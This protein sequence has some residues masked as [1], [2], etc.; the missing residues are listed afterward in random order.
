MLTICATWECL[1]CSS[2]T[3]NVPIHSIELIYIHHHDTYTQTTHSSVQSQ[4]IIYECH[5]SFATSLVSASI[6]GFS[7]CMVNANI[8]TNRALCEGRRYCGISKGR[9]RDAGLF[10][11]LQTITD[12]LIVWMNW[13]EENRM[14]INRYRL[15]TTESYKS[16]LFIEAFVRYVLCFMLSCVYVQKMMWILEHLTPIKCR[17][18]FV[19]LFVFTMRSSGDFN[20]A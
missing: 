18:M 9:G 1:W 19:L 3:R 7:I 14:N 16:K 10:L 20:R 12:P 6:R 13:S 17:L 15:F 8:Y 2:I 11:V 5:N 4:N